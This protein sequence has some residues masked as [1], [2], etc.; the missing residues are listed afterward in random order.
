MRR[1]CSEVRTPLAAEKRRFQRFFEK[2]RPKDMK[3]ALEKPEQTTRK[4][5]LKSTNVVEISSLLLTLKTIR[6][7]I[8]APKEFEPPVHTI[9]VDS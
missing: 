7:N 8:M 9:P 4:H 2:K 5:L 3:K 1:R 6:T